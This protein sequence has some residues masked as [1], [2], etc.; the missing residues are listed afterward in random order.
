[1]VEKSVLFEE[2]QWIVS[3]AES[4]HEVQLSAVDDDQNGSILL[5][6][7]N[8]EHHKVKI[9]FSDAA[10]IQNSHCAILVA[11]KL[12]LS[13]EVIANNCQTL[14]HIALRLEMR[15]GINGC[16]II[17]DSYNSDITGLQIA[18][19]YLKRFSGDKRTVILDRK[20]VGKVKSL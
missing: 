10:S 18:L 6:K 7:E 5:L 19:D 8:G 1:R 9:P 11:R 20:S 14:P 17:N 15:N 4:D 3:M 2:T 12:G 16:K 13:W